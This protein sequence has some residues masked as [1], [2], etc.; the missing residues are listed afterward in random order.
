MLLLLVRSIKQSKLL[1]AAD[2]GNLVKHALWWLAI[3]TDGHD[4]VFAWLSTA[5]SH[6]TDVDISLSKFLANSCNQSWSVL[7]KHQQYSALHNT[8]K[9]TCQ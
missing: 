8:A 2:A 7:L 6:E 1:D 3:N 4:S 5:D 9:G